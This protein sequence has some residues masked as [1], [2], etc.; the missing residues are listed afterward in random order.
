M[1]NIKLSFACIF[2]LVA[3][4]LNAL[5][6]DESKKG[7]AEVAIP[8]LPTE[9]LTAASEKLENKP[10]EPQVIRY[11]DSLINPG[12]FTD[13]STSKG[14][15]RYFSAV[16]MTGYM[17]TRFEF[18]RNPS[19]LTRAPD[20]RGTSN[21]LP[22]LSTLQDVA[23]NNPAQNNFSGNMRLRLDPTINVSELVRVRATVDIF[24]NL[25][26]GSTPSYMS[27]NAPNPSSPTSLM[28]LSQNPPMPGI[29]SLTSSIAV[30]RAW[31]EANFPIGE[32]RFGR[33]PY[34]WGLGLLYNSGDT[35][36]NNYGDQ[37]DGML[38]STRLFGHYFTPGYS[39]AYTGPVGR[40]GGFFQTAAN[41]PAIHVP[42][43]LGQ[44]YPLEASDLT[45]VFFLSFL[46]R[47]SDFLASKK[48]AEG[49]ALFDYGLFTSYRYQNLDTQ[50]LNPNVLP[51]NA[52]EIVKRDGNVGLGSLWSS[53]D[54]KTFH[55]EAEFVGIW[56]KYK[57]GQ[58]NSD[59]LSAIER[60]VWLLQGGMALESKYGFLDDRLQLGFDAGLASSSQGPG[61]GIREGVNAE[62]K[63]GDADG[64]KLPA[65]GKYKTNFKFNPAYSIDLLLYREIL[66]G[67]TG[68]YYLKPHLAY[69]FSRNFGIRGDVI[70][71]FAIDKFNTTGKSPLLGLELDG[72]SFLRTDSGFYFS[73]AY[74]VLFPLKGL[75]HRKSDLT[76][77][78]YANYGTAKTAQTVQLYFGILF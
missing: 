61:F 21:F 30:K 28:S 18:F 62:P 48:Q 19:L 11:E 77:R 68:T 3:N 14:F 65:A 50:N 76:A 25:V 5:T 23:G 54:Y 20:G 74:G 59:H 57:V 36:D 70:S 47:E 67:V 75:D 44:R 37:I 4:G 8:Q 24:D 52:D 38:F 66:G 35:I 72:S 15:P 33:M 17:R 58:K 49:R 43:E 40:G 55:I 42:S 31:G 64:N 29:N 10:A 41:H 13:T 60:D 63:E 39:I 51:L 1:F 53:F 73:L 12:F 34:H 69:F 78:N 45:H 32:L 71:S 16:D 7:Q 26:L 22:N 2:L 56:G 27:L 9:E 6:A 46:K